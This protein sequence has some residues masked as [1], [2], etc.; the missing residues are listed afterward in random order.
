LC[1]LSHSPGKC[2]GDYANNIDVDADCSVVDGKLTVYLSDMVHA[3]DVRNRIMTMIKDIM[4]AKLLDECHQ[5]VLRVMYIGLVTLR[6]GPDD[7]DYYQTEEV[8]TIRNRSMWMFAAGGIV[9]LAAIAVGTRYRY[10]SQFKSD[11]SGE[12]KDNYESEDGSELF[13]EYN[14]SV[15]SSLS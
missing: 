4:D 12:L 9:A 13:V 15:G 11:G 1:L 5:A 7:D 6:S 14:S 2:T 10:V 3:T 8:T